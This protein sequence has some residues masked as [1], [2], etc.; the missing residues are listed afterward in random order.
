M[1]LDE[2][3]KEAERLKLIAETKKADAELKKIELDYSEQ[4][5]ELAK[6]WYIKR[7]FWNNLASFLIGFSI[8]GFYIEYIILPAAKK[9]NIELGLENARHMKDLYM[10]EALLKE[11]ST[12]L[13]KERSQIAADSAAVLSEGLIIDSVSK[14]YSNLLHS[15]EQNKVNNTARINAAVNIVRNVQAGLNLTDSMQPTN[16]L[17]K[18]KIK[19]S[20][21]FKNSQDFCDVN[22]YSNGKTVAGIGIIRSTNWEVELHPGLYVFLFAGN[23]L[24][25]I[26]VHVQ[27]Q[28]TFGESD[29][30]LTI[31]PG[32]FNQIL[33]VNVE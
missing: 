20:V 31:P 23:S 24:G 15:V 6:P 27:G 10:Q 5:N 17:P 12:K 4:L 18:R 9:D 1:T 30:K 13:E 7:K 3:V 26:E 14:A 2:Q 22:V 11:D 19:V 32:P 8:L 33:E 21:L 16:I 25:T 29:K 28:D